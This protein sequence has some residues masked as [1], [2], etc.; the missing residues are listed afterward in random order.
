MA[1]HSSPHSAG[2]PRPSCLVSQKADKSAF[3]MP[4]LLWYK[5]SLVH[6]QAHM[7]VYSA[8][9]NYAVGASLHRH[10]CLCKL[11][12]EHLQL[13]VLQAYSVSL[14]RRTFAV[15]TL[16]QCPRRTCLYNRRS[17]AVAALFQSPRPPCLGIWRQ[18]LVGALFQCPRHTCLC[19]GKHLQQ[20]L[21]FSALDASVCAFGEHLQY[22]R[23]FSALDARVCASG[24]HLQQG[25]YF[26]A[27]DAHVCVSGKHLR[28]G[29]YFSALDASVC[30]FGEH[31][32]QGRYFSAL[33]ANVCV[34][35]N[36]C[37]RGMV[38]QTYMSVYSAIICSTGVN[39]CPRRTSPCV[40]RTFTVGACCFRSDVCVFGEHLRQETY[41]NALDPHVCVS[42]EHFQQGSYFSAVDA[43]VSVF[44][45]HLQQARS[46]GRFSEAGLLE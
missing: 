46:I 24:E 26:S 43:H 45:E 34:F 2:C 36:I 35:A 28:E 6:M 41:F 21:Y 29:C 38:L 44:R 17:F 42:G 27:L 18:L 14:Y 33:D 39:Q 25:R 3:A 22:R 8:N 5:F 13:G 10:K 9:I 37:G 1:H 40:Q 31:L 11:F 19:I 12:R 20:G 16:F 30:L 4:Q 15:G 32:Q 7:P 23:Y